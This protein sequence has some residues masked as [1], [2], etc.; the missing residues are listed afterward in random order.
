VRGGGRRGRERTGLGV[1]G[2]GAGGAAEAAPGAEV[3][4]WILNV[5]SDPSCKRL[6]SE[7]DTER[8]GAGSKGRRAK[9]R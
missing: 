6:F 2:K 5:V 9:E 8:V 4:S 3:C 7:H 1:H